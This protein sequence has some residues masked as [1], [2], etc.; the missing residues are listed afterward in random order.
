MI[1]RIQLELD[2]GGMGL[3]LMIILFLSHMIFTRGSSI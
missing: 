3:K 2:W 1:R